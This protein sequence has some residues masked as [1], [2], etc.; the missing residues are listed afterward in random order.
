MFVKNIK[1]KSLSEEDDDDSDLIINNDEF[2]TLNENKENE[3]KY[4]KNKISKKNK[5]EEKNT[6]Q[7]TSNRILLKN[8]KYPK[9]ITEENENNGK[10]LNKMNN[11]EEKTIFSKITEDLYLDSLNKMKPKK[12]IF[13]LS[14]TKDDNYN[15]LTVENYLF[16]CADKENS[17]NNEIINKFIERKNKEQ[18]CKKISIT[19]GNNNKNT[20]DNNSKKYSS[21]HKKKKRPKGARSPEQF[22]DDQKELEEKH[23]QYIDKLIKMHNDEINLCLKDRP[24]ISKQSEKLANMNKNN[25]KDVHLKLYEEFDIKRKKNEGKIKNTLVLNDFELGYKKKYDNEQIIESAKRLYKEYEIMQNNINENKKKKLNDIKNLSSNSLINKNS[26]DIISKRLIEIYK[27]ALN[28]LFLKNLNDTFDFAFGDF[29]LFIYKLVDKDYNS[30]QNKKEK[31]KNIL[32]NQNKEENENQ[33]KNQNNIKQYQNK[34]VYI[35]EDKKYNAKKIRNISPEE[36][37]NRKNMLDISY[38]ILKRNTFLKTKSVGKKSFTNSSGS[39]IENESELKL[40]KEAWKIITKNKTFNEELLGSSKRILLFFL[41]LCGIYKGNTND[42]IIKKDFPFLLN[43]QSDMINN[44]QLS[45]QIYRK[46]FRLRNS[47]INNTF[48]KNKPK[49]KESEIRYIELKKISNDNNRNTKSFRN[50]RSYN[51]SINKDKEIIK[52]RK[53]KKKIFNISKNKTGY[54]SF[55]NIKNKLHLNTDKGVDIDTKEIL[56]QSKR[57]TMIKNNNNNKKLRKNNN[58]DSHAKNTARCQIGNIKE[59][60][61]RNTKNDEISKNNMKNNS[62]S[63][64]NSNSLFSQSIFEPEKNKKNNKDTNA[65][66]DSEHLNGKKSSISHYIFN[67]DYRIKDDI[68]SNSNLNDNETNK[69]NKEKNV[70]LNLNENNNVE[71]ENIIN[72]SHSLRY[73][74]SNSNNNN[75]CL[76]EDLSQ[77]NNQNINENEKTPVWG[78]KKKFIFKI[79]IRDELIKLIVN[80]DDDINSIVNDFCKE[81]DLDEDDKEQ[82]IE[83]VNLKL[84]GKN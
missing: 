72:K 43:E 25:N 73:S 81:N 17:K 15:K 1:N 83:V 56:L 64:F 69:E 10:S 71:K 24:T 5:T 48:E 70:N 22:L 44:K 55:F 11:N 29:L 65:N 34:K 79:K 62:N 75:N 40:A 33:D 30:I 41:N 20:I 59:L 67:E 82:I 66:K 76:N 50:K 14:K 57:K 45:H 21:D 16:T 18:V 54:K 31:Y 26:K 3:E 6:N 53:N 42:L 9:I 19:K 37:R 8:P 13:D 28:E 78:K 52:N 35:K 4:N 7:N 47:I 46:F 23:K 80:K 84:L 49:K 27:K 36:E 58:D 32:V 60:K 63:S 38:K 51:T 2:C 12:N 39:F 61:E 74:N 77:N 68:E